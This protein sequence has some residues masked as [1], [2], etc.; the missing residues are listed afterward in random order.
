[1]ERNIETEKSAPPA[2]QPH[3]PL[4]AEEYFR[5]QPNEVC[6]RLL[7]HDVQ[8]KKDLDALISAGKI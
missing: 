6:R 8:F 1:M 3:H 5:M 7:R 2:V 4:T